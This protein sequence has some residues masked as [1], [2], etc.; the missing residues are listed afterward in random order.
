MPK[1]NVGILVD[2]WTQLCV[3]AENRQEVIGRI[4][5]SR[6]IRLQLLD[7]NGQPIGEVVGCPLF[8]TEIEDVEVCHP[9]EETL[10]HAPARNQEVNLD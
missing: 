1:Y 10:Y 7:S 2:G 8:H 5:M 6:K 4:R 3:R 9:E